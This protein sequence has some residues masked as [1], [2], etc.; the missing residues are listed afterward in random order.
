MQVTRVAYGGC[1]KCPQAWQRCSASTPCLAAC[2][3]GCVHSFGTGIGLVTLL[4]SLMLVPLSAHRGLESSQHIQ[5]PIGEREARPPWLG[6][7]RSRAEG[8][9]RL[10][11]FPPAV[12]VLAGEAD[13][14]LARDGGGGAA[15]RG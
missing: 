14:A 9:P 13:A 4:Q 6:D 10:H 3:K 8:L 15:G 12:G 11:L 5:V 1:G 2:Q 7:E